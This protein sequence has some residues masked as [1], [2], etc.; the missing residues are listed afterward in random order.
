M[1]FSL[2]CAYAHG[3]SALRTHLINMTPKQTQLTWPVYSQLRKQWAGKVR[4]LAGAGCHW[5]LVAG[6]WPECMPAQPAPTELPRLPTTQHHLS[7]LA[8]PPLPL[9]LGAAPPI[10]LQV[11]LQAV[12]LVVL[13]F[14]RDEQA[15]TQ[16]AD[17][18][19]A[20]GGILGAAVCCA[21]KGGDPSDDWTTCEADRDALLDR[22]LGGAM[23]ARQAALSIR[24]A[25]LSINMAAV[26]QRTLTSLP[27]PSA[28]CHPLTLWLPLPACL[29]C[30]PAPP[31]AC[32]RLPAC[33]PACPPARPP[34]CLPARRIFALA[35]ARNLDLDFHTDENGN[36]LARGLRYVAQKAVQHGYQGRVV[37]GHC[38]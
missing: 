4:R 5:W 9:P 32:L 23:L 19:A 22:W 17:L 25:A 15:A 36:E 7:P 16:L 24:Q 20:H 3:T 13:S 8:P 35:K 27:C 10:T 1:D 11:E 26:R 31:P 29:R 12:S 6:L 14:F 34:A 21:E 28:M 18:V 2:R 33:P 30:L 38:W 37:C